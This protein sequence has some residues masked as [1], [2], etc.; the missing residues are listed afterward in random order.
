MAGPRRGV[1]FVVSAPSGTGKTSVCRAVVERD[2]DI[3]FSVSHTTR[4]RRRGERDGVDYVFV[5]TKEFRQLVEEGAFVEHA[6][7]L[8]NLYGT[9]WE[10]LRRPALR[11]RDVLLEI[12]IQGARQV[13]ERRDLGARLIFLVPPSRDALRRRLEGRGTDPAAVIEKRLAMAER[14]LSA[15]R[16]FD[17]VVLND[18]LDQAVED[19]L[20]IVRAEREGRREEA[21]ARFGREAVLARERERL[22]L[23]ATR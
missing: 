23:A 3:R 15:V 9:S 17:Y 2:P 14:E 4:P 20:A 18:D 12:E 8:G 11:G 7:Y 5:D 22:G 10:A 13:A 6:E 1:P 21:V 19:V 16:W